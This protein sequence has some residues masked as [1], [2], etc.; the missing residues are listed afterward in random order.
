MM[1][2]SESDYLPPSP[3]SDINLLPLRMENGQYKPVHAGDNE[4]ESDRLSE[5][6]LVRQ[7][8]TRHVAMIRYANF[9]SNTHK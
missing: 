7:L 4:S 3:S 1:I 8:K 2:A 5:G 6:R 9:P